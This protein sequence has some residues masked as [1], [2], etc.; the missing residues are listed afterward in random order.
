WRDRIPVRREQGRAA[1][2][3]AAAGPALCRG[4]AAASS[5]HVPAGHRLAPPPSAHGCRGWEDPGM[6]QPYTI[7][8]GLEVHVQLLTQTKLFYRCRLMLRSRLNIQHIA[9]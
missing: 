9:R 4:E 8:I 7:V 2:R 3:F 6:S 1:D 5:A